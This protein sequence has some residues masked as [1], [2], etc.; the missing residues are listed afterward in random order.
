MASEDSDEV[1]SGLAPIHRLCDAGDLDETV[2][3]QVMAG[4]HAL[5]ACGELLEVLLLRGSHGIPLEERDNPLQ[6]ILT[7]TDNVS[8]QMLAVVVI[9]CVR[10]DLS[11]IEEVTK[12]VETLD[13]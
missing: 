13:A 11:H 1:R 5:H 10:Q 3:R 6:Q 12:V 2:P 8:V 7:P 4:R 9:A